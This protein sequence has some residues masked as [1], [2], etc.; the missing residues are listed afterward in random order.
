MSAVCVCVYIYPQGKLLWL[1]CC[2]LAV[3]KKRH[4]YILR[5]QL[6]MM[7][8]A[9]ADWRNYP[10]AVLCSALCSVPVLLCACPRSHM[11]AYTLA[12]TSICQP[13][14]PIRGCMG[15]LILSAEEEIC[16]SLLKMS[17][18]GNHLNNHC[19]LMRKGSTDSTPHHQHH[20]IEPG[21]HMVD[22]ALQKGTNDFAP[23]QGECWIGH[24]LL[25]CM[26]Q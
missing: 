15:L 11:Y 2:T 20:H 24:V 19:V 17:F 21:F 4:P 6:R 12:R 10:M 25:L 26:Y 18:Y 5:L 7:R 3:E 16:Q 9:L 23:C 13:Q 14:R 22:V 1:S 8:R